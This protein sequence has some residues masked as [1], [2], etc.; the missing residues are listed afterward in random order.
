IFDMNIFQ[1]YKKWEHEVYK[2]KAWNIG[3]L[4]Y[5]ESVLFR[6][7]NIKWLNLGG[8][9]DGWFADPFILSHEGNKIEVLAEE[10]MLNKAPETIVALGRKMT[11]RWGR[12]SKLKIAFENGEYV[13][14]KVI[15]V[16]EDHLHYSFPAIY[17][18]NGEI[19]IHPE[20]WES[21][22]STLFRYDPKTE[23]AIPVETIC[24]APLTDA[25][26][27]DGFGEPM[28]FATRNDEDDCGSELGVYRSKTGSWKGPYEETPFTRISFPDLSARSAGYF[29]VLKEGTIVRAAQDCNGKYGAGT[30]FYSMQYNADKKEFTFK[31]IARHFPN[32]PIWHVGLH[33]FN[34]LGNLA[35]VDGYGYLHPLKRTLYRIKTKLKSIFHK[36]SPTSF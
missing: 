31:E 1:K 26:I 36:K 18:E 25:I 17:R 28:M 32:S 33:T 22:K 23:K 20:N 16:I 6:S 27:F 24:A 10:M 8:Y 2:R 13:L 9:A 14:K 11:R 7:F 30:V 3:F 15:P 35:T 4:D 12:I 5:D 21:E 19:Y 29:I 34:T